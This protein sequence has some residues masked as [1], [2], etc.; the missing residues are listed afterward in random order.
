MWDARLKEAQAAYHDFAMG[1][2]VAS[3]TDQNGERVT[4]N[5]A[6]SGTLADYI[7]DMIALLGTPPTPFT[8]NHPRPM[9]FVFGR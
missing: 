4:F 9:R 3:F 6:D 1:Q 8:S 5:K 7:A 2:A